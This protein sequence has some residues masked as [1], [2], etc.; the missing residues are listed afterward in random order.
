MHGLAWTGAMKWGTQL[1]SWAA[2]LIIARLLTPDDYGVLTMANVY[3]G[4]IAL[5]NE[6]GLGP[7]IIRQ[8]DLTED[9]ISALGGISIALSLALWT[10][11]ALVAFPVAAFFGEPA[12]RWVI[13]AL[14]LNFITT[15]F[16]VLPRALMTRDLQFKRVAAMDATEALTSM[17]ITLVLAFLGYRYWSLVWGGVTGSLVAT[18]MALRWRSH[19]R[20]F[21][22]DLTSV[23]P[24][25][26]FG[27]HL[28]VS[29]FAWYLYSSADFA[30]V[31]RM[32][33]KTALGGYG[34]AWTL[35]S[36]PV[37]RISALVSQ[38]TPAIFSAV[39]NDKEQ[40]SRYF[41]KLS[42][43]LAFITF[44][45][46]V[47]VALVA[48]EFVLVA[49]GD[50]W[51]PAIVPL[52]LLAFYAGFRS[53][54]T[55]H[56]QVLQSVG[57]TRDQMRFSLLALAVLPLMFYLGAR[58]GGIAGVAWGWIIGYPIVMI[59]PYRAVFEATGLTFS[60]YFAALWPAI[61]GSAG[62]AAA[63]L[64]I[65]ALLP[66]NLTPLQRLLI[67]S[68]TGAL[69]YATMMFG[70]QRKRVHLLREMLSQLKK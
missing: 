60:R 42:E 55:L 20:H 1:L 36:I 6:F 4:F 29:R 51:T 53:L 59:P 52:Q 21:P 24:S 13:M 65:A 31:G 2:T 70:L 25:L 44:P 27:W 14:S 56:P 38:V 3:L 49:L 5:V 33:G 32:L 47:G 16:R 7:A 64:G 58:F 67:E 48:P 41:L 35:A 66:A 30:V 19:R 10:L 61:L 39:Q 11:S 26:R 62:M 18:V 37:T 45:F 40:L 69:V 12:V 23:A 63:V 15:G 28:V 54:T 17:G 22:R 8:R 34:F 46:S 43:G 68:S 50:Q 9:Q 57:R